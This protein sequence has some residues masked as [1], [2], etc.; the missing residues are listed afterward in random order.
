MSE[1]PPTVDESSIASSLPSSSDLQQLAQ[2]FP[3]PPSATSAMNPLG[4]NSQPV[5]SAF[6]FTSNLTSP[7]YILDDLSFLDKLSEQSRAEV[8]KNLRQI[9]EADGPPTDLAT[10]GPA[11]KCYF[12]D[13]IP[14]EVRNMIYKLLLVNPILGTPASITKKDSFGKDTKYGL[15]PSILGTCQQILSEASS[16]LY[17]KNTFYV[18]TLVRGKWE[19]N[20]HPTLIS[21]ITRDFED[22]QGGKY[23]RGRRIEYRLEEAEQAF[24][25]MAKVK[26]WRV[27]TGMAPYALSVCPGLQLFSHILCHCPPKHMEIL[28]VP[29]SLSSI[30]W[31]SQSNLRKVTM[32]LGSLRNVHTFHIREAKKCEVPDYV[33][34]KGFKDEVGPHQTQL[35]ERSLTRLQVTRELTELVTGNS[36]VEF[37]DHM[38]MCLVNYASSF[39]RSKLFREV[40]AEKYIMK[41]QQSVFDESSAADVLFKDTLEDHPVA[42]GLKNAHSHASQHFPE[43]FK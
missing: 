1:E 4:S 38:N 2:S 35:D 25:N 37:L 33:D 5:S 40:M 43:R 13:T 29:E 6:S 36:P 9:P 27:F 10:A 22:A 30:H 26:R 23:S 19:D 34:S 17:E 8:L 41:I 11:S 3:A 42:A 24:E 15:E 20:H 18:S 12:L 7:I 28:L 21:A 14:I 32:P 39:E 16:I 31:W